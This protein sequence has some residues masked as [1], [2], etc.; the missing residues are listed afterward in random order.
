MKMF[1]LTSEDFQL[2][3]NRVMIAV[4][5]GLAK[6]GLLESDDADIILKNYS[7]LVEN[8]SWMPQF[9][10]DWLGMKSDTFRYRLVR[11]IGR[12]ECKETAKP[13]AV[14]V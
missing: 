8:D 5:D 14:N 12:E 2:H 13:G 11:A 9:L 3:A 4:V 1:S 7:V 10:M 6:E